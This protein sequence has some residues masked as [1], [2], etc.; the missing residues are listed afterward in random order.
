MNLTL[1]LTYSKSTKGTHVYK[2][3]CDDA[4]VPSLYIRKSALAGDRPTTITVTI[5]GEK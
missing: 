3:A 4:P 2:D 1:T 5:K